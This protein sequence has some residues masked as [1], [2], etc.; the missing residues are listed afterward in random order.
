[1]GQ[2]G[3]EILYQITGKGTEIMSNLKEGD[4]VDIL[5]PLGRGFWFPKGIKR[6]LLLQAE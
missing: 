1:V 6:L 3:F 4:K 5:G 2:G